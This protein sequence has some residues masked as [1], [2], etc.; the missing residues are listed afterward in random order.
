LTNRQ[1]SIAGTARRALPFCV[2]IVAAALCFFSAGDRLANLPGHAPSRLSPSWFGTG[3]AHQA[4]LRALDRRD[5]GAALNWAKRVGARDPVGEYSSGLL[6]VS[7]LG[8][9]QP[10]AAQRAYTVA[11]ST[12]WRDEGVQT[13]WLMAAL[14]LGDNAVAA[15]RLDAL[16]RVGNRD[17]QTLAGLGELESSP[18]G[19]AALATRLALGPDWADW[20]GLSLTTIQAIPFDRRLEVMRLAKRQRYRFD[21]DV[22]APVASSLLAKGRIIDAAQVWRS[23][24]REGQNAG[25]SLVNGGFEQ[26][27]DADA[28]NPFD[29]VLFENALVDVKID[30]AAPGGGSAL[31]VNSNATTEQRAAQQ[32]LLLPPGDYMLRWTAVNG[33]GERTSAVSVNVTCKASGRRLTSASSSIDRAGNIAMFTITS[34]CDAQVLSI[35]AQAEPPAA[36]HAIWVDNIGISRPPIDAHAQS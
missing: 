16:L 13:Y 12:G 4:A 20:Y 30:G 32:T 7:M 25:R 3:N 14:G 24:G 28:T 35:D 21:P 9:G 27:R 33:N 11:A 34:D 26:P 36:R 19:R 10:A 17:D 29:W 2:L 23:F 1:A 6:G 15:E 18:E 8:I 22:I 31:Y 5:F